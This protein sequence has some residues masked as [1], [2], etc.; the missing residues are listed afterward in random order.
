[1]SERPALSMIKPE[2]PALAWHYTQ[3]ILAQIEVTLRF[4]GPTLDLKIVET[5]GIKQVPL[6]LIVST[7]SWRDV[8][9]HSVLGNQVFT[10]QSLGSYLSF[11]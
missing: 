6:Q 9:W 1:M 8:A 7:L 10:G 5:A 11:P 3:A 4:P 2:H